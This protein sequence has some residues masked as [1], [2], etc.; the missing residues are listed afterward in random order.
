VYVQ[1]GPGHVEVSV[2]GEAIAIFQD[3]GRARHLIEPAA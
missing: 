3:A 1:P 2:V